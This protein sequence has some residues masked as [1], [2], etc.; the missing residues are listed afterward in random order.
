[1]KQNP[2]PLTWNGQCAGYV[3]QF[4]S[5]VSVEM[6][7]ATAIFEETTFALWKPLETEH[8]KAFL[9]K[10]RGGWHAEVEVKGITYEVYRSPAEHIRLQREDRL[11]P[12][13]FF[14]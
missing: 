12:P 11:R 6:S 7:L 4:D 14:K 2:S 3:D 5:E 9:D 8:T 10:I 13:R 1:M